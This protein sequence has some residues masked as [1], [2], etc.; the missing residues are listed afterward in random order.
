MAKTHI[1]PDANLNQ[2][3]DLAHIEFAKVG[4]N[5]RQGYNALL[6]I[7]PSETVSK[8]GNLINPEEVPFCEYEVD[9]TNILG[10][11]ANMSVIFLLSDFLDIEE[12]YGMVHDSQYYMDIYIVETRP[13]S[14]NSFMSSL[15]LV[16]YFKL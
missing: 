9:E 7:G 15:S 14:G 3:L 11:K 2:I 13:T 10:L 16:D 8:I 12:F 4:F 5:I 6:I 1:Q